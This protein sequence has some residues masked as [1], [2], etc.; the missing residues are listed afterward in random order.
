VT[1]DELRATS[2]AGAGCLRQDSYYER[3][4]YSIAQT[5]IQRGVISVDEL[6]RKMVERRPV[7]MAAAEGMR[8]SSTAVTVSLCGPP[9]PIGHVRTPTTSAATR[10]DRAPVRR[11]RQSRELAYA[12]PGL[13]KQPLYRVR[14]FSVRSGL[15]TRAIPA[16]PSIS[17]FSNTG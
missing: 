2:R 1:V 9:N 16:I 12:R 14:F 3:W 15:R 8:H 11:I 10:R 4:I 17:K 6:G 5:L 13:P 7:P